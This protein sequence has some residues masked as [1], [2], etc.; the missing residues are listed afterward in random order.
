MWSILYLAGVLLCSALGLFNCRS[1]TI[2]IVKVN[3]S[4]FMGQS[5]HWDN[6][7]KYL[8]IIQFPGYL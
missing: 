5:Q 1:A 8:A 4:L 3:I 6:Q 7:L 2:S